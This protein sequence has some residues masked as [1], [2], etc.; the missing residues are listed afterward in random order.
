MIE[1]KLS[2]LSKEE[3]IH[4][5]VSVELGRFIT[6][7]KNLP[8]IQTASKQDR[9][10][11]GTPRES[12]SDPNMTRVRINLGRRNAFSVPK[13]FELINSQK[14][15]SGIKIGDISLESNHTFV[16]VDKNRARLLIDA[17]QG[18]Q[19]DGFKLALDTVASKGSGAT[20]RKRPFRGGGGYKGSTFRKRY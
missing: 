10:S 1:E 8:D 9:G 16:D 18:K 3:L 13:L 19:F 7:Y 6:F 2:H 14:S 17:L 15:I 20:S 5:L 4:H 11:Y 12:Y